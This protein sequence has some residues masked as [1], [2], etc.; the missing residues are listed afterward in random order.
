MIWSHNVIRTFFD[1]SFW[2][3]ESH[4]QQCPPPGK[5]RQGTKL[6]MFS[7]DRGSVMYQGSRLV[8]TEGEALPGP[9][10]PTSFV[11]I[12]VSPMRRTACDAVS[13]LALDACR[14]SRSRPA[15]Q[16]TTRGALTSETERGPPRIQ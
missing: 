3:I 14:T 2:T 13:V 5:V 7:A 9:H 8:L 4:T 6:R 1:G 10:I 12:P 11:N 15:G 16:N